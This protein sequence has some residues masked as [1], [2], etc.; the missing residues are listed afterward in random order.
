MTPTHPTPVTL[1]P[2]RM[3]V[4]VVPP[5]LVLAGQDAAPDRAGAVPGLLFGVTAGVACLAYPL[6][7]LLQADWGF[8]PAIQL[9]V[10]LPAPASLL[11]RPATRR[12]AQPQPIRPQADQRPALL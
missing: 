7:G 3:Q 10:A 2:A 6:V 1:E 12:P 4:D 11:A 8:A 5:L 9:T